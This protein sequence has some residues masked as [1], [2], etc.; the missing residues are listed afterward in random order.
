MRCWK[1]GAIFKFWR[2]I[3]IGEGAH[4]QASALTRAHVAPGAIARPLP[5]RPAS[6]TRMGSCGAAAAA[7]AVPHASPR[8]AR[9]G[10]R[11]DA[12][13]AWC[14]QA[15]RPPTGMARKPKAGVSR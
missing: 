15:Q 10:G 8:A 6:P 12:A 3:Q 5:M 4:F 2:D 1:E 9:R 7:V 14:W 11:R 13:R